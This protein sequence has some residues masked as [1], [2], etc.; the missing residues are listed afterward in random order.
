[1]HLKANNAAS[2]LTP[3]VEAFLGV[4]VVRLTFKEGKFYHTIGFGAREVDDGD[5]VGS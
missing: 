3:F 2:D 4:S 5:D 1:M